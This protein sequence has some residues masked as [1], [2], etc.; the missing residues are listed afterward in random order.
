VRRPDGVSGESG[1]DRIGA[2]TPADGG[3]VIEDEGKYVAVS[4]KGA[5]G[6]WRNEWVLW[7]SDTPWPEVKP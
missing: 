3:A 5:D 4:Q 1:R 2:Y 7:N 6:C